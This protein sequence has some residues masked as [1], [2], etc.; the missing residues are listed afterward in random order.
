MKKYLSWLENE[1]SELE[2]GGELLGVEVKLRVSEPVRVQASE[3]KMKFIKH[4]E[5]QFSSRN[6]Y[7]HHH[8]L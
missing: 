7:H 3:S 8:W 6:H 1:M 5:N 2:W 4:I